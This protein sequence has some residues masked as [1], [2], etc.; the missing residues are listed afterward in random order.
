[1]LEELV[2]VGGEG[3]GADEI[4]QRR[5]GRRQG[6]LQ[7]LTDLAD[8]RAWLRASRPETKISFPATTVTTG[9]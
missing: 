5:P 1:M 2:D 9:E 8:L 4:R 3:L 7:V 6:G